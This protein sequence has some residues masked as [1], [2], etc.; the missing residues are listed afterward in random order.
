MKKDE[1]SY[2]DLIVSIFKIFIDIYGVDD[3][4]ILIYKINKLR[5][6]EIWKNLC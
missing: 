4:I 6:V 2:E 3:A 1:L 5:G